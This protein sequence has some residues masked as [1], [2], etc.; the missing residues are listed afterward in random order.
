MEE[1]KIEYLNKERDA[2]RKAEVM[3]VE[4]NKGKGDRAVLEQVKYVLQSTPGALSGLGHILPQSGADAATRF[5]NKERDMFLSQDSL[6]MGD[7]S[8][9]DLSG[10]VDDSIFASPASKRFNAGNN[11]TLLIDELPEEHIPDVI[12]LR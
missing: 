2:M 12:A 5:A 7:N 8:K 6:D 10:Y 11:D 4:I 1:E 9:N 3:Q